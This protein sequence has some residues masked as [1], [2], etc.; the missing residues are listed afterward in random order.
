MDY[1]NRDIETCIVSV[2]AKNRRRIAEEEA[3]EKQE[4]WS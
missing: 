2:A 1:Y 3:E 4:D